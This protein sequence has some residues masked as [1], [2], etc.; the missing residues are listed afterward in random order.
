MA[1]EYREITPEEECR[2]REEALTMPIE[3]IER[4]LQ[5]EGVDCEGLIARIKDYLESEKKKPDA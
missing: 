4:R 2:I 5:E 1:K 3:E